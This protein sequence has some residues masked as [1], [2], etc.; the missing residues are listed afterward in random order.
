[1]AEI[2]SMVNEMFKKNEHLLPTFK[3][4]SV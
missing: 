1:M 3:H 2:K 4:F